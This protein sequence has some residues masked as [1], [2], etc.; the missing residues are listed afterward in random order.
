MAVYRR[1]TLQGQ[2]VGVFA[3]EEKKNKTYCKIIK[4]R[5]KHSK[6]ATEK[7]GQTKT[8]ASGEE[9]KVRPA[10]QVKVSKGWSQTLLE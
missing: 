4:Y 5:K 10:F 1:A 2:T 6:N 9:F 7:R 3:P 8:F